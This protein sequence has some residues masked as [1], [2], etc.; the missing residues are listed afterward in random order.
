[1]DAGPV[2][3]HLFF[4][5]LTV[6]G[7]GPL[8]GSMLTALRQSLGDDGLKDVRHLVIEEGITRIDRAAIDGNSF[9]ALDSAEIPA[10]V[11]SIAPGAFLVPVAHISYAGSEAQ[12]N[13][14]VGQDNAA[15]S[16][17]ERRF[18]VG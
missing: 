5:T 4:D 14:V 9:I 3:L 13:A 2:H 18:A 1:M 16:A 11:T 10:S 12:W 8:E 17:A 15:L 7:S 6:S